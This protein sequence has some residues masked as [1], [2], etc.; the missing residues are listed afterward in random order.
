MVEPQKDNF[1]PE[2]IIDKKVYIKVTELGKGAY[3][4][5]LLY[6]SPN[7]QNPAKPI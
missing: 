2:F 4:V 3:G 6:E 5:V 7:P 1:P